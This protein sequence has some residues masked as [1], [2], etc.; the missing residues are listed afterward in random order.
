MDAIQI[1]FLDEYKYVDKI[2]RE[3]FGTEKGVTAYI[4]QLDETPMT[5]RYWITEWNNEYRQLKHIRWLRNQ[6]AHSTGYVE[7]TQSDFD[8]LKDFHNR[9]LTQQDLLAKARRVIKESQ[10][11]RQQ[12]LAKTVTAAAP[13]PGAN[14]YR[15]PRGPRKSL[16]LIAVIA[17]LAIIIGLLIWIAN[18]GAK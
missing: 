15:S 8:W 1:E 13:K 9:L 10:I 18:G 6:I 12:Q 17:A 16:I 4:E 7:C 14:V 2:C 5:V 3:M 11:Q